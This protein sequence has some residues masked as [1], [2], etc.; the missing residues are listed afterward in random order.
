[1]VDDQIIC[2]PIT[3]AVMFTYVDLRISEPLRKW[4]TVSE[5]IISKFW[6][7]KGLLL[8]LACCAN[9]KLWFCTICFSSFICKIY[10]ISLEH[11]NLLVNLPF[12]EEPRYSKTVDHGAPSI[13]AEWVINVL[14]IEGNVEWNVITRR[15]VMDIRRD[16]SA[17]YGNVVR[18]DSTLVSNL[19]IFWF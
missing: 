7:F 14:I 15:A 5:T 12:K 2:N 17:D 19:Y 1:M 6:K 10:C 16:D 8:F 13:Y 9:Y 3:L 11:L 4:K 18:M